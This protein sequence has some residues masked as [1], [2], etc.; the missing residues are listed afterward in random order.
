ME[1]ELDVRTLYS[2]SMAVIL[3]ELYGSDFFKSQE[4][5]IPLLKNIVLVLLIGQLF[6]LFVKGFSYAGVSEPDQK[7]LSVYSDYIYAFSF[8][9]SVIFFVLG[10]FLGATANVFDNLEMLTIIW[11]KMFFILINLGMAVGLVYV[12]MRHFSKNNNQN[13][14]LA[15]YVSVILWSIFMTLIFLSLK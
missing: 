7:L 14:N 5:L 11:A 4:S 12:W 8:Q 13:T 6:F 3:Y 2:L 15:I 10:I 9:S 1:K